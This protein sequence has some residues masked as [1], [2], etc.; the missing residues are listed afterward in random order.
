MNGVCFHRWACARANESIVNVQFFDLSSHIF[1]LNTIKI[2]IN[3]ESKRWQSNRNDEQ[4]K[5]RRRKKLIEVLKFD[6]R[7]CDRF[8]QAS[9]S[10]CELK[11][12]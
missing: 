7:Q 5:K 6:Q 11:H 10:K 12:S 9:A 4:L 2:S 8:D 1:F 3:H